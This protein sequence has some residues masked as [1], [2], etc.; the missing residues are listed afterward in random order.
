M[1]NPVAD[2]LCTVA[3]NRPDAEALGDDHG[4]RTYADLDGPPGPLG[5]PGAVDQRRLRSKRCDR[6]VRG[7]TALM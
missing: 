1:P 3:A 5:P 7:Q 4:V 2:A 6:L